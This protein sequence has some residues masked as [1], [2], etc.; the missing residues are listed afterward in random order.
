MKHRG[1]LK[2][3]V[4]VDPMQYRFMAVSAFHSLLIVLVFA[5]ALFAPL[6]IQLGANDAYDEQVVAAAHQF[7]TLHQRVWPPLFFTLALLMLH[8]VLVSHRVAGPLLRF[9]SE[10]KA[11]GDGDLARTVRIRKRDYLMKEANA[12]NQMLAALREKVANIDTECRDAGAALTRV[13]QAAED[14]DKP[15]FDDAIAEARACLAAANETLGEFR[16]GRPGGEAADKMRKR[17]TT[18]EPVA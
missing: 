14:G 15:R 8:S 2:R 6:M 4:L 5:T 17:E 18:V 11:I 3:R 9:R 16:L 7:M 1:I 12:I 13:H 10:F